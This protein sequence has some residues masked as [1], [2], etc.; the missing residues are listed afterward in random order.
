M[1]LRTSLPCPCN[2]SISG[3]ASCNTTT[4]SENLL[5]L[6]NN[7][8]MRLPSYALSLRWTSL[9]SKFMLY[10]KR[11]Q[12]ITTQKVKYRINKIKFSTCQHYSRQLTYIY[13]PIAHMSDPHC[14][15]CKGA[16]PPGIQLTEMSRII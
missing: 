12:G 1:L 4:A 16:M 10:R 11:H 2:L 5:F 13:F 14:H 7:L 6:I 15:C 9:Y 8:P 3:Q